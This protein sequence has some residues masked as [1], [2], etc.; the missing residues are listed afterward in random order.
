MLKNPGNSELVVMTRGKHG[1]YSLLPFHG[2]KWLRDF[3]LDDS[4]IN[5]QEWQRNSK[6]YDLNTCVPLIPYR[7]LIPYPRMFGICSRAIF[8][9]ALHVTL[10]N[11]LTGVGR[12]T[13]R[14][15]HQAPI[16]SKR[17]ASASRAS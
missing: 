10:R 9:L 7:G 3:G 4:M 11:F 15:L 16:G 12:V 2:E 8:C 1:R 5:D 13:G 14:G 6:L 17:S